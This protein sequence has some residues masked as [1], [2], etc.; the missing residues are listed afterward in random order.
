MNRELYYGLISYLSNRKIPDELDE[1]TRLTVKRTWQQFRLNDTNDLLKKGRTNDLLVVPEHKVRDIMKLAHDHPLSGHMGVKNTYYRLRQTH[2]WPA[3]GEDIRRHVE[4][5]D[6]CQKQK[7]D[8]QTSEM[9]SARMVAQPFY[10]IGIDV[11][12]PLPITLSG[13]RYVVLAVDFFTK[14]TEARSLA[15]ANAQSISEFIHEDII[16]RHGVPH[17]L[18]SDRGTEFVN[19]LVTE[20]TKRYKMDHIRTTAYHPQGNGQTERMNKTLK[21]VLAKILDKYD[22]WDYYLHSALF[23]MRNIRNES[24]KYSPFELLYGRIARREF[25]QEELTKGKYEDRIW[26]WVDYD[27]TRLNRI[28]KSAAT[29]ISHAQ[30]QQKKLYDSRITR[31]SEKYHIGDKVLLYRNIIE[32]SWSKEVGT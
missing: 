28:R 30:E 14:W 10:H 18:T 5:C 20:L 23:A 22:H 31:P 16:C 12:G 4:S 27:I 9:M 6:K 11:I 29:F 1:F 21:L 2:W 15:H 24:T 8:K 13:N 19:Q 25:S 17:E 7:T 26:Q 3:M 32:S